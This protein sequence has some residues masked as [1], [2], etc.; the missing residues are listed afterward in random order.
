MKLILSFIVIYIMKWLS[1]ITL[2]LLFGCNSSSTTHQN[3]NMENSSSQAR[4]IKTEAEWKQILDPEAFNV[5]RQSGTEYPHT[6]QYNQFFQEG[7]YYCKGCNSFLFSSDTKFNS[8]CGWPSFY[9]VQKDAIQ[10][11][12]DLSHGMRRIEVRCSTCD[13]HLGHV[14]EDGPRDKTGLRYCINSAALVFIPN[15]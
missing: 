9:D 3:I 5:L 13:G 1:I 4:I 8:S 11:I 14:F 7:K 12:Q 10:Y 6:G 2:I 15:K